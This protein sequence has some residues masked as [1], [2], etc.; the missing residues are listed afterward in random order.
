MPLNPLLHPFLLLPSFLHPLLFT[1]YFLFPSLPPSFPPSLPSSLATRKIWKR[2]CSL[3]HGNTTR[4]SPKAGS[5]QT[6]LLHT[7]S[8][9][10][11]SLLPSLPPSPPPSLLPHVHFCAPRRVPDATLPL[12]RQ[13]EAALEEEKARVANY[14]NAETEEKLLKVSGDGRAGGECV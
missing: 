9:H 1:P 12:F 7:C 3:T 8:R 6:P 5:R 11:V 4:K 13:A 14:L 2:R 10:A